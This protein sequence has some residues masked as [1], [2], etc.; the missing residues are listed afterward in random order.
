MYAGMCV[1]S[2]SGVNPPEYLP[3]TDVQ[4]KNE[5]GALKRLDFTLDPESTPLHVR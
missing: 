3:W 5:P 1:G 2:V 4:V